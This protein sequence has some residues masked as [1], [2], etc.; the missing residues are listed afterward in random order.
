MGRSGFL[1]AYRK[2]CADLGVDYKVMNTNSNLELALSEYLY[3]RSRL[4]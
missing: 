2:G 3:Q 1:R 4:Y